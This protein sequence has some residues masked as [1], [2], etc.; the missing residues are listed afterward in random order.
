M[1]QPPLVGFEERGAI[2]EGL[3]LSSSVLDSLN[4]SQFGNDVMAYI[5]NR[6]GINLLLNF[7]RVNYLSSAV[8]TELLRINE[9]IQ[10]V[11]GHLRLC[12]LN[13]DIRKVFE[14]TNLD[15]IFT[16][17]GA[18]DEAHE[19]FLRSLQVEAQEENWERA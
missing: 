12:A 6:P 4:V 15:K 18:P 10:A 11:D 16:I 5:R 3:I 8:L 17:Y 2:T 7:E 13:K 19:R 1:Q 9:A 14:I